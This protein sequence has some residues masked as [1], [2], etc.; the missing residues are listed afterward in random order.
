MTMKL[1]QSITVGAGGASSISF[2]SIP[3]TATDL[4]LELSSR[5]NLAANGVSLLLA[6]NGSTSSFTTRRFYGNGT[7]ATSESNAPASNYFGETCGSSTTANTFGNLTAT[8]PNYSGSTNKIYSVDSANENNASTS[9]AM[10][11]AGIW[12]STAAITSISITVETSGTFL[13]N[14]TASLYSITKGS[15]GAT[16]A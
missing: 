9:Y 13:Q 2:S 8:F 5:C 3:Q 10:I 11:T 6:I 1:I 4:V 7:G 12:A 16:V 15:G 14:T